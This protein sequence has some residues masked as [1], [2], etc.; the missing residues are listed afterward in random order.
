MVGM[1]REAVLLIIVVLPI[2]A[3]CTYVVGYFTLSETSTAYK[4]QDTIRIRWFDSEWLESVYRPAVNA[5]AFLTGWNVTS[6]QAS[7][8]K[9]ASPHYQELPVSSDN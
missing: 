2:L 9:R 7:S 5:E 4:F 1:K 3:F 6:R 8:R